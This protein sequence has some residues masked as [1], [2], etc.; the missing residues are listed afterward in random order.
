MGIVHPHLWFHDQALE[1][2]EFYVSIIPNSSITTVRTAPAGVP[3]VPEGMPFVVEFVLD[4]MPVTALS[5]G[6]HVTLNEAI[7]MYV[8]CGSQE[9][10]DRYW[11][12]LTADGGK[13]GPCGWLTDKFGLSW[14]VIPRRA[15]D[16]LFGPDPEGAARA[17]AAMLAMSKFDIAALEAAYAG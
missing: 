13:P 16:L 2:A 7:S 17:T 14:Q 6:P 10:V 1:A 5:G 9:E 3:D 4:G 8:E 11:D 15:D 12:L